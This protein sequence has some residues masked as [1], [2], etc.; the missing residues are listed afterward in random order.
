MEMRA[1]RARR[2]LCSRIASTALESNAGREVRV[3]APTE[4]FSS[5]ADAYARYRPTYPRGAVE[6]LETHCGLVPGAAVADLG[7]GTGILTE[8]LLKSGAEVFA[9]EPNAPMRAAA[10]S[11]LR[12]YPNFHSVVGSAEATTLAAGS[13][14]LLVVGQAFHWFDP[15]CARAEALRVLRAAA[16]AALLWNERP[17]EAT[18]FLADYEALLLEHAAEYARITASRADP[19]TMRAFLGEGMELATFPNEQILDFEGLKGRLM[20]SSYA[21]EPGQPQYEPIMA[22]LREVF[23]RHQRGGRIVMPYRTLVYFAQLRAP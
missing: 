4:R 22:L 21:P 11:W 18:P 10:E 8:L 3:T 2:A 17:V 23:D 1:R 12:G 16:W 9:V 19:S 7:S 5:R 20:S 15:A 13:V 14:D 6:L